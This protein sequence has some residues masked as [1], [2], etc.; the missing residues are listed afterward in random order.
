MSGSVCIKIL[1]DLC[2]KLRYVFVLRKEY[3]HVGMLEEIYY[4]KLERQEGKWCNKEILELSK[5]CDRNREKL[6]L[7]MTEEQRL[8]FE[9]FLDCN[10]E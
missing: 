2:E 3:E 4:G 8:L 6:L 5:L 7:T 9:K 10:D 1:L